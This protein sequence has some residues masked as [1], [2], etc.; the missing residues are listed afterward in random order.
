MFAK[1]TIVV[2]I[3]EHRARKKLSKKL[4]QLYDKKILIHSQMTII[5]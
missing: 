2:Q 4:T 3:F 5:I 1:F